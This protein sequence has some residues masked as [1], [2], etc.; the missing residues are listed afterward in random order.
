MTLSDYLK[1]TGK[2]AS[3]LAVELDTAVSTITRAAKGEL[4]P[5]RPLMEAI[6]HATNGKVSPNDFYG[7]AV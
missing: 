7:I 1:E 2:T 3:E 6:H 5:S 4:I